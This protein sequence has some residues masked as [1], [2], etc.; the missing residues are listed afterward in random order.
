MV[1]ACIKVPQDVV[2]LGVLVG[3]P[4]LLLHA[5]EDLVKD[6]RKMVS[7]RQRTHRQSFYVLKAIVSK[8]AALSPLLYSIPSP[9]NSAVWH[10]QKVLLASL[11]SAAV[12][13]VR[14]A[15]AEATKPNK[16]SPKKGRGRGNI[17]L[18]L[19]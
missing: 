4:H 1:A 2:E 6:I 12:K 7:G 11:H 8:A 13:D 16:E 5:R 10:V 19:C 9:Q 3:R 18:I 17:T 14:E 15:A